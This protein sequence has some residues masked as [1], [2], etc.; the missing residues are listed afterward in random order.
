VPALVG[1]AGVIL[2][3]ASPQDPWVAAGQGMTV[4]RSWLSS[5]GAVT[6]MDQFQG[7]GLRA[8]SKKASPGIE[9]GL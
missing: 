7:G 2:V 6:G 4:P 3:A 1:L 8:D 5:P 9:R